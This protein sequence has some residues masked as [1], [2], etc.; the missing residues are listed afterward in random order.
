MVSGSNRT[1][2]S[3]EPRGKRDLEDNPLGTVN[4]R[5]MQVMDYRDFMLMRRV[6][7]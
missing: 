3:V 2:R 7:V 1:E 6:G 4:D 5:K